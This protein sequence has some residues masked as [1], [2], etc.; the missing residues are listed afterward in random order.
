MVECL[1]GSSAVFHEETLQSLPCEDGVWCCGSCRRG[2]VIPGG[3][4][5]Q[6]P[7]FTRRTWKQG[8]VCAVARGALAPR[9]G[10]IKKTSSSDKH[11][12]TWIWT[13]NSSCG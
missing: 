13:K 1:S 9:E 10:K 4:G 5:G 11:T 7:E 2:V 6:N 12:P 8:S 3:V